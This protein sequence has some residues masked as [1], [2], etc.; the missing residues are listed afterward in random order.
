MAT[1]K[2]VLLCLAAAALVLAVVN[3]VWSMIE[4]QSS[5]DA[6]SGYQ[7]GGH[8]FVLI[9]PG[10]REVS[11]ATWNWLRFHSLSVL[12]TH[13]LGMVGAAYFGLQAVF[14]AF[15][16]GTA[17][18]SESAERARAIRASGPALAE[19]QTGGRIGGV[20]LSR[21]MMRVVV[22]PGGIVI[23]PIFMAEQTILASE[24]RSVTPK[25]YWVYD[26]IEVVHEGVGP[27]SPLVL[28]VRSYS[29]IAWAI[30]QVAGPY[31]LPAP[32]TL[33]KPLPAA[34]RSWIGRTLEPSVSARP[35]ASIWLVATDAVGFVVCCAFVALGLG[36]IAPLGLVGLV[37]AGVSGVGGVKCGRGLLA[38]LRS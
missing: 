33:P 11:Q 31:G 25:R 6:L 32:A 10:Y 12:V 17:T 16:A 38:W 26:A 29:A 1:I 18:A 9:K 15:M 23:K 3:F 27:R 37:W 5:G 24:I 21:P 13:P 4:I 8:Y 30:H 19:V 14:P 34:V 22:Y 35:N 28:Y 2:N 36:L 7:S 20:R